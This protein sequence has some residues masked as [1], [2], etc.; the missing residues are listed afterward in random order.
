MSQGTTFRIIAFDVSRKLPK[1]DILRIGTQDRLHSFGWGSESTKEAAEQ[2]IEEKGMPRFLPF[3]EDQNE[4]DKQYNSYRQKEDPFP[5]W[6][7]TNTGFIG[8]ELLACDFTSD[9]NKLEEYFMLQAES[10][11][12]CVEITREQVKEMLQVLDYIKL[13]KYDRDL[14]ETFFSDNEFFRPLESQFFNFEMRFRSKKKDNAQQTVKIVIEDERTYAE[15]EDTDEVECD[16]EVEESKRDETATIDYFR[17]ILSTF[18]L[19]SPEYRYKQKEK[20]V[21]K[22]AYF[23]WI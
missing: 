23:K 18:L 12:E 14:E 9:F 15:K 3:Y 2:F 4:E 1:E 22:L 5:L 21:L 7:D 10:P 8:H 6:I 17:S 11:N 13:G 19:M 20:I 16:C